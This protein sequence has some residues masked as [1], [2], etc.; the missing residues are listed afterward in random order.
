MTH[1]Y[2]VVLMRPDGASDHSYGLKLED[3]LYVAVGVE[4]VDCYEAERLGKREV[5]DADR[6]E[7]R[8]QSND[9]DLKPEDYT[10][11]CIFVGKHRPKWFGFQP[12]FNSGQYSQDVELVKRKPK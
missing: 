9:F 12:G 8:K 3:R 4:A 1:K 11:L 7:A 6:S 2:T 10:M 5:W